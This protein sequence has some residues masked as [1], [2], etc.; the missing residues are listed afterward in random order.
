VFSLKYAQH[1]TG[2]LVLHLEPRARVEGPHEGINSVVSHLSAS[3]YG[4]S[5]NKKKT[6]VFSLKYEQWLTGKSLLNKVQQLAGVFS[7]Q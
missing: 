5:K 4:A 2:A 6:G 1:S 3:N 7:L